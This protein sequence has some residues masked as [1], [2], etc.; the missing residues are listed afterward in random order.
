MSMLLCKLLRE[1]AASDD[2][3]I[4]QQF[5]KVKSKFE[6]LSTQVYQQLLNLKSSHDTAPYLSQLLLRLDFN[7]FYTE[8]SENVQKRAYP[9]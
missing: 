6:M 2:D 8:L 9:F 1:I 5:W 4:S 7:D 3:D